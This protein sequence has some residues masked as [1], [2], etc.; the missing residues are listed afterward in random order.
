[1]REGDDE[2][3]LIARPVRVGTAEG[4]RR[5]LPR[6]TR[7]TVGPFCLIDHYGP[8]PADA[9]SVAPHPHIGITTLSWLFSGAVR[10]HDS[11]G[12]L[13]TVVPGG[14]NLMHSRD[15]IAHAEVAA[16]DEAPDAGGAAREGA[17]ALHGVQLWLAERDD[18]RHG[19]ASFTHRA[20]VEQLSMPNGVLAAMIGALPGGV[21]PAGE[22]LAT[23][24]EI[25]LSGA[26]EIPLA[27]DFEHLVVHISG[28][29]VVGGRGLEADCARY[30][31][32]GRALLRLDAAGPS[33]LLLLGGIPFPEPLVMWWN[34]VARSDEEIRQAATD[35][36]SGERF[37][38][39]QSIDEAPIPAPALPP[40]RL[41]A[42]G[43]FPAGPA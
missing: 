9:M 28:D 6:A 26:M 42:R 33:C 43:G 13:A 19:P 25:T 17:G 14:V 37:G 4:V 12:N 21:A 7:T 40:G 22:E 2:S 11:L 24:L 5:L 1:V 32:P 15:G 3:E 20:K 30:L 18:E 27:P 41:V 10:H 34:F 29:P 35:W 23:G 8:A 16:P 39:V 38:R 31:A 36:A